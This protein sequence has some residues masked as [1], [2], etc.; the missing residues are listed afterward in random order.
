MNP[1]EDPT[2]MSTPRRR[3]RGAALP[4]VESLGFL[5]GVFRGFRGLG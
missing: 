4:L 3:F 2:R 1:V 5:G